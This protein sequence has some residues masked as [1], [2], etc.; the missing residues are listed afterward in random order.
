MQQ[1]E[2]VNYAVTPSNSHRSLFDTTDK[3]ETVMHGLQKNDE[4]WHKGKTSQM[5]QYK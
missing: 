3:K 4:T 5:G 2:N 1:K